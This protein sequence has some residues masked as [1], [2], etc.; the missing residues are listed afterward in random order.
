MNLQ[1][2]YDLE[3]AEKELGAMIEQQVT[4][5]EKPVVA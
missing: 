2:S 4:P 1:R 3:V 5:L